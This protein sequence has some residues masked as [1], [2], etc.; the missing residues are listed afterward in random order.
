M[1]SPEWSLTD[2]IDLARRLTRTLRPIG[3]HVGMTGSVL[4]RGRSANDLDLVIYPAS[5]AR[6]DR[7]ALFKT[8]STTGRMLYDRETTR[9]AWRKQ[10]AED[11]KDVE[12]WEF[13]GKKVDLFYLS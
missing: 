7:R 1:S 5:T 11:E 12:V 2:G 10:D 3:Y 9:A 8:L 6:M 4:L 13:D